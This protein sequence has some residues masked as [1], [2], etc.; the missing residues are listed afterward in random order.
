[1]DRG[2][3]RLQRQDMGRCYQ[4]GL[5]SFSGHSARLRTVAFSRDGKSLVSG[6]LDHM[7]FIW[8]LAGNAPGRRFDGHSDLVY[9]VAFSSDGKHVASASFDQ[10]VIVWDVA[11]GQPLKTLSGSNKMMA[12]I[13]SSDDA[14]HRVDGFV[15]GP[16]D[17]IPGLPRSSGPV[18]MLV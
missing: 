5:R 1:M 9:S 17:L 16:N 13:F 4:A 3:E 6:G 14:R 15:R 18:G 11:S 8:D 7:V 10:N 12:A 2:R